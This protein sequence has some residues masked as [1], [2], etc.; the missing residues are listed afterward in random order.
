MTI[1]RFY[2]KRGLGIAPEY[3][4]EELAEQV[5]RDY[6]SVDVAASQSVIN[7]LI[8]L[9]RLHAKCFTPVTLVAL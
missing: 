8:L 2:E 3:S 5:D 4:S 6:S 1:Q 9:G 7:R